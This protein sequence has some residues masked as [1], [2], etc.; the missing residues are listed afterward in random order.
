MS[1]SAAAP[2][3]VR[4]LVSVVL[5]LAWV[6]ACGDSGAAE[7]AAL[8]DEARVVLLDDPSKALHLARRGLDQHGPRAGLYEVAADASNRLERFSD[9]A[10]FALRGLDLAPADEGLRADLK[11]QRGRAAFGAY[12]ELQR[13]EDW[14]SANVLLD[15]AS[16]AGSQRVNAAALLVALHLVQGR[17]DEERAL[18]FARLVL[19][20]EPM[21]K[22]ASVVRMM[23]ESQ[24]LQP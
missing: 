18:R 6:L 13:P 11:Y 8:E 14:A 3:P 24:G 22:Q 20:L 16:R 5:L 2:R 15:E 17:R 1:V 4:G 21:G 19:E 10:E 9:A 12:R 23:L 7:A